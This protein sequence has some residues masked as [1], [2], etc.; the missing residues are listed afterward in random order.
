MNRILHITDGMSKK[1]YRKDEKLVPMEI[2]IMESTR[3]DYLGFRV[4]SAS[5]AS[6]PIEPIVVDFESILNHDRELISITGFLKQTF[7]VIHSRFGNM[8][9][10]S[11]A[12]TDAIVKIKVEITNYSDLE[13]EA[14]L[15]VTVIGVL[16]SWPSKAYTTS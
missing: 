10:R 7:R 14:G 12:I 3:I 1:Y 13:Y 9:F 2:T 15:K 11:A 6:P 4:V 5:E 16:Y 8:S